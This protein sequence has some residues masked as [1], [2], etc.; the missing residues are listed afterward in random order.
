MPNIMNDTLA[1]SKHQC[2]TQHYN[3]FVTDRPKTDIDMVGIQ[4]H[5]KLVRHGTYC[6]VK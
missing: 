4:F 1:V 2:N 5:I 3:V 6:P